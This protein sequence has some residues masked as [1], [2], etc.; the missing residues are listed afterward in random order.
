ML[1]AL[2]PIAGSTPITSPMNDAQRRRNGRDTISQITLP[3]DTTSRIARAAWSA[4]ASA[5]PMRS[6]SDMIWPKANTPISTG[7]KEMPP[8]M[9]S[10]PKASRG[11]PSTGSPPS[12]VTIRPSAPERRPFASEDS[13]SPATIDSASTKSEKYSHGPNSSANFASGP[14]A[15]TSTTAPSS[16]PKIDAQIPSQ[17]AR[18]GSPLRDI[19]NPSKVVATADGFPGMPSRHEAI[20]PPV[21]PPT[22]TPIIAASPCSGSSPKVKGS[23]TITVSVIVMPGSAPPTTPISVPTNSGTRYFT[24]K[25]FARPAARSSYIA[26]LET[27]PA[28]AREQYEQVALEHEVGDAG[29]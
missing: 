24:A 11:W 5:P 26:P 18:P 29:S 17:T 10:I 27:G 16:P 8:S 25:M 20:S 14:V 23:T 22:Y 6:T 1:A 9:N 12:T 13:T 15:P 2:P 4:A 19:G 21:S 3:C 28:P 7:R